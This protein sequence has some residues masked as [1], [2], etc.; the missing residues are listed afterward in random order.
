MTNYNVGEWHGFNGG[1]CPVHPG[2]IVHVV[3]ADDRNPESPREYVASQINWDSQIGDAPCAFR[4]VKEHREP[5][6]WWV[7]EYEGA[8][9]PLYRS[10]EKADRDAA[11]GRVRCTH[12][13]EVLE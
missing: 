10:K 6:E 1:E 11:S 5:R 3:W 8:L 7:N 9:S 12:V 4:V 13:R 2:T